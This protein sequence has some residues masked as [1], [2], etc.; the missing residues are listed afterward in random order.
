[1]ALTELNPRRC[2]LLAVD[3]QERL[4]QAVAQGSRVLDRATLMIRGAQ[5][6]GMPVVATTQYARGLGGLAQEAARLLGGIPLLDKVE[7]DCFASPAVRQE[8]AGLPAAVDTV[9]I[10]GVE[11]HICILQTALGAL[12]RGLRP[13]V[14]SD[15]VSS[16]AQED[17]RAAL[18]R[19][20]AAGVPWGSA[21]MVLYGLLKRAGT[22]HFKAILPYIK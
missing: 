22:P 8:V 17:H 10:V 13:W 19:L 20:S 3:L 1:M 7:F 21:E 18:A 15:A 16:R 9:V 6:M 2:F 5:L 14:V 11:S 12:R 4:L